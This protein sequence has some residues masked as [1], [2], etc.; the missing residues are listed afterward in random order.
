VVAWWLTLAAGATLALALNAWLTPGRPLA[1]LPVLFDRAATLEGVQGGG[2]VV[3]R[4]LGALAAVQGLRALLPGE[5]AADALARGLAP[6][7]RAGLPL[8]GARAVLG[9]SVRVMPMLRDEVVRVARV[10]RL[11]AGRAP[12]GAGERLQALRAGAV[13]ALTGALERADR[14]ALALEAR[15]YRV[16][17]VTSSGLRPAGSLLGWSMAAALVAACAV[18]RG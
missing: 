6:L 9:L 5:A 8:G 3:L 14:V 18:W 2:L 11:R 12:R 10:Q 17:P 1:M 16:R 15:H 7:E 4:M 13:P